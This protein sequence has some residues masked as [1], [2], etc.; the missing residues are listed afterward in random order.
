MMETTILI[1]TFLPDWKSRFTV[2]YFPCRI[3]REDTAKHLLHCPLLSQTRS[4]SCSP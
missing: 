2:H 3:T 4:H 1:T